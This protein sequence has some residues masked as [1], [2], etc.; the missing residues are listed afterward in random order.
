M[1]P[2][3]E[4]MVYTDTLVVNGLGSAL[5]FGAGYPANQGTLWS[6]PLSQ[7]DTLFKNNRWYL[8]TN[9]RQLCSEMYAEHG[10]VQTICDVPVDDALRGGITIHTSQLDEQQIKQIQSAMDMGNDINIVGQ[11]AKWNRLF[12]GAGVLV[13]TGQD[14]SKPLD[15]P[16]LT[17]DTPFKLRACDL[18]ELFYNEQNIEGFSVSG[19][20]ELFEFYDFYGVKLHKSRVRAMRGI[21]APSFIRP[22]MRGWGLS[23]IETLVR[24]INQ[25]FKATDLTFEVLDE[26]KLDVYKIKNL[27]SSLLSPLGE[28]KI[29]NR[30]QMANYNK[31]FQHALVMDSEDDFDHKQ[32]SFAGLAEVMAGVRMQ[33]ASDMRMPLT[34]VFGI[35]AAGFNSGEDDIEVYNGMVESQVRN[36]I[37]YDLL[38]VIQLRCQMLFGFIPDDLEI[39]FQPLR[40]LSAEQEENVK[41]SKFTRLL[42][43]KQAGEITRFEFREGCNKDRLLPMQLDTKGDELN[44]DDPDVATLVEGE[45]LGAEAGADDPDSEASKEPGKQG[46]KSA[47]AAKDAKESK[48]AK[49]VKNQLE[50]SREFY[51]RAF[52]VDGGDNQFDARRGVF[53]LDYLASQYPANCVARAKA[54]STKVYGRDKWQFILWFCENERKAEL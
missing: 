1:A 17:K 37:K 49:Q 8:V 33:I 19:E 7:A 53:S 35:S 9:M 18:W 41:T 50:K 13:M 45:D 14:P 28:T 23:V 20:Q 48:E 42:Q 3:V 26:F 6:A 47:V 29:R 4:P 11:A 40:V 16:K 39:E 15:I 27:T 34:K 54:Q 52:E 5:G 44:A 32:L 24:S 38:F 51:Q 31:N 10:V 36:K 21:E 2:G 30:L 25:Y 22:R 12:G 43:A 46:G